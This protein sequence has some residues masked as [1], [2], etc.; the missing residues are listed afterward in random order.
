MKK[1]DLKLLYKIL[2]AVLIAFW[3]SFTCAF[4][5]YFAE[6][7]LYPLKYAEQIEKYCAET[8][9]NDYLVYSIIKVE[10]DFKADAVSRKGATGLM[11]LTSATA[12]YVASLNG[13]KS[14]ELTLPEDN[15]RLGCLYLRYLF[16]KFSDADVSLAA[17][18]AGEGNAIEWLSDKRYSDDGKTLKAIPFKET[19]EYV[20]KIN[21]TL[22]KY[23]NLYFN[24]VDK[25]V[26][27]E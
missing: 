23:K 11:Q 20:K 9:L 24:I 7:R 17:Y 12:E 21:K 14:F 13:I 27:F 25:S 2:T 5:V 15:I 18:N 10:S 22:I 6:R 4:I 3:I 8:D 19:D 26:F 1:I 16:N